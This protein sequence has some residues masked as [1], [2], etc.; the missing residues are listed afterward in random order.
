[1]NKWKTVC[2]WCG[3]LLAGEA[4]APD[5]NTSHGI[6]QPCLDKQEAELAEYVRSKKK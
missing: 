1:M 3:K 6:C 2:A 5:K 4:D